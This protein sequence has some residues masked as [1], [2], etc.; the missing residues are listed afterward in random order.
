MPDTVTSWQKLQAIASIVGAT[1]I[2]LGGIVGLYQLSG[3][4]NVSR[5]ESALLYC[6]LYLSNEVVN[7][8]ASDTVAF[9]HEIKSKY[10]N[11]FKMG[12]SY[13]DVKRR[14]KDVRVEEFLTEKRQ[15]SFGQLANYFDNAISGVRRKVLDESIIRDCLSVDI[16]CFREKYYVRL[17]GIFDENAY[18][19]MMER[20]HEFIAEDDDKKRKRQYPAFMTEEAWD[21][22]KDVNE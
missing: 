13:D 12:L 10:K 2:V 1:A 20:W 17:E 15:R 7:G 22:I 4:R 5:S 14:R 9:S 18:G 21:K 6:G 11:I 8:F 16:I 19:D 3:T